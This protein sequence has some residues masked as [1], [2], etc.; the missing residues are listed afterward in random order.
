MTDPLTELLHSLG[1]IFNLS[2]KPDIYQ[3]CSLEVPPL[4]IQLQLDATQEHLLLFTKVAQ[5]P[6]GKFR[7]TVLTE[8]LKANDLNDPRPGIFSYVA[9]TN[10]LCLYQRYP[11]FILNGDRLAGLFGSFYD[12]GVE[13]NKAIL[14]GQ[15]MSVSPPQASSIPFGIRP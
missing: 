7:E 15:I 5:L 14:S 11:L 3:S 1:T 8:A 12:L 4:Q 6:P 10:H 2:L 13:W 9:A